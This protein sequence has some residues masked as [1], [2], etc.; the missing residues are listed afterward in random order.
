MYY[1]EEV[2]YEGYGLCVMLKGM[3][4]VASKLGMYADTKEDAIQPWIS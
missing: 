3:Y 2:V 4:T 1:V